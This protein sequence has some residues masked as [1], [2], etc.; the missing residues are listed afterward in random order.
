MATL[1]SIEKEGGRRERNVE[2]GLTNRSSPRQK[3][4]ETSV[5]VYEW[6]L[7]VFFL[8]FHEEAQKVKFWS[9]LLKKNVKL[10]LNSIFFVKLSFR[11]WRCLIGAQNSSGVVQT[12]L[13]PY[14]LD[15]EM[16]GIEGGRGEI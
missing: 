16:G 11:S 5:F 9:T 7:W 8:Q 2:K 15:V 12:T 1:W 13:K 6:Q 3:G 10:A 14:L 4:K